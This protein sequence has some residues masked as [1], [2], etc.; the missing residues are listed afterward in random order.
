MSNKSS[1]SKIKLF[2]REETIALIAI[3][4]IFAAVFTPNI[5]MSLRRARDQ[6]RR[7]DMG[8]LVHSVDAYFADLGVFPPSTPD[9]RIVACLKEG[10]AP[11]KDKKGR[12]VVP[13][14]PCEWGRDPLIDYISGKVYLSTLPRDPEWEKG[15]EYY[16]LSDGSRYQIY[17]VMEGPNE[18]EIDERIISQNLPCG[19]K[20]CNVGRSYGCDIPK[21]L[22]MCQEEAAALLKK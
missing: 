20:V 7:D 6:V 21:T 1:T 11:Y 2:T 12:W 10:D 4:L 22:Q 17:G 15:A 14:I 3:F 19:N 13:A 8:V 5:L 16:Y 9:G 18:A